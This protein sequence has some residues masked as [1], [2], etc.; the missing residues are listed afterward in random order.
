MSRKTIKFNHHK[1]INKVVCENKETFYEIKNNDQII[2]ISQENIDLLFKEYELMKQATNFEALKELSS[3][4]KLD[5]D[6]TFYNK[7]DIE[8][9]SIL[10][11]SKKQLFTIDDF[12]ELL[13]YTYMQSIAFVDYLKNKQLISENVIRQAYYFKIQ[14]INE[15]NDPIIEKFD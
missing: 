9:I 4:F 11:N 1:I 6:L 2:K 13:D 5:K 10:L 14:S 3:S 15:I 12:Q 7:K 8:R